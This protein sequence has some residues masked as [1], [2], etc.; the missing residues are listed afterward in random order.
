MYKTYLSLFAKLF[1]GKS[2]NFV[3]R[4][5]VL[6]NFAKLPEPETKIAGLFFSPS[7]RDLVI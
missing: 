7:P 5:V 6:R 3:G 2:E 4:R 1:S